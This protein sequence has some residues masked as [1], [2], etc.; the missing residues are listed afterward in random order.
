ME[1]VDFEFLEGFELESQDLRSPSGIR[2][3][4]YFV[5]DVVNFMGYCMKQL[6]GLI[7]LVIDNIYIFNINRIIIISSHFKQRVLEYESGVVPH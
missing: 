4:V 5:I 1:V 2:Q 6:I 7:V 3:E